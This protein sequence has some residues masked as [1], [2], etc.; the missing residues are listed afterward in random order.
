MVQGLAR[1]W[2]VVALQGLAAILFGVLTLI[3]PAISLATLILFFGAYALV[4][5]VFGIVASV[6]RRRSEPRWLAL[7]LSGILGVAIGIATLLMP[8]VTALVLLYIIAG[9]AVIRGIMEI[10]AA[11]QLR[12]V[13][14]GEFWLILAGILSVTFGVLLFVFP[15]SGA[16]AVALWIGAF[17]TVFGIAL[18]ALA[19]RLRGWHREFV[20]RSP[21]TV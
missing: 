11:I 17:A 4:D 3:N 8:G 12:K 16:L 13:I 1:N 14:T 7:L 19:L 6:S 21:A 15:G 10:A 9:W 20:G 18:I 2:W 5:G